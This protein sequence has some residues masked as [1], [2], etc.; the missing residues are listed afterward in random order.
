MKGIN[1]RK[2]NTQCPQYNEEFELKYEQSKM[3]TDEI[4]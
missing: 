2:P 3:F 4:K 1:K